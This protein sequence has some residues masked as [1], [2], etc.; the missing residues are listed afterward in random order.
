MTV[1]YDNVHYDLSDVSKIHQEVFLLRQMIELYVFV[2][3]KS[4]LVCEHFKS[5]LCFIA[6]TDDPL[7]EMHSVVTL[8]I[9]KLSYSTLLS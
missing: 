2:F 9:N 4:A 7:N 1:V 6:T 5:I 8:D 3:N